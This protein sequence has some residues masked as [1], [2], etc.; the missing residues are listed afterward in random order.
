M[1]RPVRRPACVDRI[2]GPDPSVFLA[3]AGPC[4]SS[5]APRPAS[6]GTSGPKQHLCSLRLGLLIPLLSSVGRPLP[7]QSPGRLDSRPAGGG[8]RLSL[9]HLLPAALL[10]SPGCPSE[11]QVIVKLSYSPIANHRLKPRSPPWVLASPLAQIWSFILS[12]LLNFS[13]LV[14]HFLWHPDRLLHLLCTSPRMLK[15]MAAKP[16]MWLQDFNS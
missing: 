16:S 7:P 6:P 2:G 13:C 10:T 11:A 15:V 14:T 5:V 9:Q 1:C 8:H 3:D 12:P 4:L